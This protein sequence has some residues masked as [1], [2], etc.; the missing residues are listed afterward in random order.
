MTSVI[1]NYPR[2][3]SSRSG[4]GRLR[5]DLSSGLAG[6]H[7]PQPDAMARERLATRKYG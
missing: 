5:L 6:A 4:V 7:A 3:F 2:P 1:H